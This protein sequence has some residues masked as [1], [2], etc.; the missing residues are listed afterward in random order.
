MNKKIAGYLRSATDSETANHTI[1][2]QR[3]IIKKYIADYF[4]D[5]QLDF[6]EDRD[7]SGYTFEQREGYQ[8]MRPLLMN[9]EYEI[10]IVNDLARFSRR[11]SKGLAELENL[12]E[13]SIRF[14]SID[15]AIDYPTYDEWQQLTIKFLFN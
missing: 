9:G 8:Q 1:E 12:C 13:H 15:D 10:L 2:N 14:I 6:Y 7:R 5:Y 4:P 11:N 3:A